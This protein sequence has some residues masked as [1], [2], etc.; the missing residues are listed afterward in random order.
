[1]NKGKNIN[2]TS[3]LRHKLTD[4][5]KFE[6]I[7]E[8]PSLKREASLQHFSHNFKQKNF[9]TKMNL[10]NCILLV[11]VLLVSMVLLK[12]TNFRLVFHFLHLFLIQLLSYIVQLFLIQLLLII[13]LPVSF[14]IFFHCQ[15]LMITLAKI[16]FVSQIKNTNLSGKLLVSYDATSLFTNNPLQETIDIAINLIVNNNPNLNIT[17]K[18]LKNTL[19]THFL[20]TENFITK[21]ME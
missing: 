18:K 5:S 8:D 9:L 19:Q 4:T 6:K 11:L 16:L 1:M 2:D 20:L 10:I 21:L 14:A 13:T 3:K 17:K 12:Y 15:Y 7:S